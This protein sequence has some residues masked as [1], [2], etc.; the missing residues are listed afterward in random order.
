MPE[1]QLTLAW[2]NWPLFTVGLVQRGYRDEDIEKILGG[3]MVRVT[4]EV[5]KGKT[6]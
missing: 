4:R 2:T 5:L 1:Q 3:N 6:G